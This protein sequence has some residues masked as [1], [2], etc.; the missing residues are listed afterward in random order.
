[1]TDA[2]NISCL[3]FGDNL[4][5]RIEDHAFNDGLT[6]Q[7]LL[8]LVGMSR[9]DLHRKLSL[10]VG[11]SATEYIRYVR[12]RRAS[13]L[14]LEKPELSINEAALEVGFNSQSYF[15]KRFREIFGDSPTEWRRKRMEH[16]S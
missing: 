3:S 13:V 15:S 4:C 7:K 2:G 9:T 5:A 10:S 6:V 14:L 11:M 1:M 8:R 16:A 12:L